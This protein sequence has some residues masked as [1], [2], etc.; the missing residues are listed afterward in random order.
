MES[1]SEI[2]AKIRHLEIK[3][4]RLVAAALAGQYHS[5]F[6]GRGMSFED[7]RP[8]QP[9][10]DTRT[11]DWNV[12]AR[13]GYPH[14]KL[15][16]EEREL[17]LLLALD[18]SA[19]HSYG[20]AGPSKREIAAEIAAILALSATRNNDRVGLLLF[21]DRVEL[22][23]P[24]R[25][26]RP[27]AL[28]V[29]RDALFFQPAGGGTDPG[30]ALDFLNPVTPRRV[31]VFLISDFIAPDFSRQLAVTARRHDLVAVRVSDPLELALPDAGRAVFEDP[32]TGAQVEFDTSD[33]AG[34]DRFAAAAAERRASLERLL[35]RHRVDLVDLSTA[36]DVFPVLRAFFRARE[37][38]LGMRP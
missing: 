30:A 21:T 31:A 19:S 7:V 22:F 26:G 9:G 28:R 12:T 38:R 35:A 3:T 37:R 5:V 24:P 18:A 6:R 23:L 17:T 4:R 29:I 27:H 14:V 15:F 25:K 2:L 36:A 1:V 32:E 10:D 34:R 20:S 8:Y 11:I 16:T 13:A 33:R